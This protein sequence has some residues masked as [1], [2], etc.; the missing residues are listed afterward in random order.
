VDLSARTAERIADD[1][2]TAARAGDPTARARVDRLAARMARGIATMVLALDP[3]MVVVGGALTRGGDLL[4]ED[5]RRHVLPL[6][7]SPVRIETSTL[8]DESVSLGA[9]RLALDHIEADLF[10]LGPPPS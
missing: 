9:V 5:L 4:V 7:L 2:L 6:C 1:V 8:G 3:E 10:R